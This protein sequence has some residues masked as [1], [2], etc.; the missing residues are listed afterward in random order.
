MKERPRAPGGDAGR[1]ELLGGG[2]GHLR[3]HNR[4]AVLR[5]LLEG[6]PLSRTQLA[7]RLGLAHPSVGAIVAELL[8]AGLLAEAPPPAGPAPGTSPRRRGRQ[9]VPLR[10]APHARHAAGVR[11]G[12]DDVSVGLVDLEANT[13]A[14]GKFSISRDVGRSDPQAVIKQVREAVRRAAQRAGVDPRSL[15]GVGVSVAAWVD[16]AR[17]IVRHM[18]PLGWHDVPLG[19]G[20]GAALD[21]PVLVENTT[22]AMALAEAWF[23]V[24]REAHDLLL[25]HVGNV[26]GCAAAFGHRVHAGH[27]S[28]AGDLGHLPAWPAS[29]PGTGDVQDAPHAQGAPVT[30]EAAV[31]EPALRQQAAT[32]AAAHPESLIARWQGG[33]DVLATALGALEAAGR[34]DAIATA[35]LRRRASRLAP[36]LAQLIAAYDPQVVVVTGPIAW[37]AT[38]L[39][40]R[41]LHQ[42]VATHAPSPPERLPPIVPTA[43]GPHGP[44]VGAASLVLQEVYSPPLATAG[45]ASAGAAVRERAAT[46]SHRPAP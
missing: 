46:L 39:Q 5:S 18:A 20:L 15:L 34:E 45:T 43:F 7:R 3:A 37:D 33:T 6:G 44:V 25:L 16:G 2:P 12:V 35:L 22:R 23:G 38:R 13:L 42:A 19:P 26:V 28:A 41:L 11:I 9:A 32:L 8:E 4:A 14:R 31:S 36:V 10:L 27:R 17:G 30:L 24:G 21:L 40:L 29:P 1:L